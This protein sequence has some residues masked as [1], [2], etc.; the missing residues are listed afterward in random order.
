MIRGSADPYLG[1]RHENH[2]NAPRM[3]SNSLKKSQ[4]KLKIESQTPHCELSS[5]F[6]RLD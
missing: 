6:G 5:C 4:T 1:N 3:S 2:I